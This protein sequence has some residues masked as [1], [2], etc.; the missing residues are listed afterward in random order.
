MSPGRRTPT[1]KMDRLIAD[2]G[3][4]ARFVAQRLGVSEDSLRL[5]RIGKLPMPYELLQQ[6]C[7][8]LRAVGVECDAEQLAAEMRSE[9]YRSPGRPRK[10]P[11]VSEP[12]PLHAI[13]APPIQLTDLGRLVE[14]P[15]YRYIAAGPLTDEALVEEDDTMS[16]VEADARYKHL[17]V[18]GR[19]MEPHIKDGD[20]VKLDEHRTAR[21]GDTVIFELDEG[22]GVGILRLKG[23]R[24]V[25]IEKASPGFKDIRLRA[26]QTLVIKG[27]VVEIISR[28]APPRSRS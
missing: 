22:A 28:R 21:D 5:Y 3:L 27:V 20:I 17:R 13:G 25:K 1:T 2:S 19:S 6:L 18:G 14:V 10:T 24:P 9:E 4:K 23:R 11:N 15:V 26:G 7:T 16:V 8:L 12:T